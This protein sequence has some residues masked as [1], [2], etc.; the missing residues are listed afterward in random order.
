MTGTLDESGAAS[1]VASDGTLRTSIT[2]GPSLVV[3][4]VAGELD[5]ETVPQLRPLLDGAL[6]VAPG[7][8]VRLDLTRVTFLG[9]AGARALIQSGEEI[10]LAGGRLCVVG[11]GGTA[12]LLAR[13]TGLARYVDPPE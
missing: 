12:L 10:A 11:L 3:V 6:A 5:C 4:T 7:D 8:E 9:A 13:V 1:Y 2:R